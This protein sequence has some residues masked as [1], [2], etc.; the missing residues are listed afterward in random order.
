MIEISHLTFAYSRTFALNDVTC[1]FPTGTTALVGRNG[2]G[3]TTL[4]KVLCGLIAPS[5]GQ[6][7]IDGADPFDDGN[8]ART[9]RASLGWVPQAIDLPQRSRVGEFV[10]YCSWLGGTDGDSS[11]AAA[12]ALDTVGLGDRA[13]A[14]VGALSGGQQRRVTIA[15]AIV[16]DPKILVLDE[17]TA[18]LDPD[19]RDH[20]HDVL[21]A[22]S[23][24]RT[25]IISTHLMEDV[26]GV[27]QR[28][29]A[30]DGGRT[31][32]QESLDSILAKTRDTDPRR[33]FR[34]MREYLYGDLP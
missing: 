33:Q 22:V 1:E 30:L 26:L 32:V 2:A 31:V 34:A 9:F 15:C 17:P 4:L 7:R 19:Q 10:Q 18:G 28:V 14:R 11:T 25:T 3:K 13:D 27:A 29:V 8:A 5:A 20:L 23:T 16:T 24:S 6:V 21:N 12:S